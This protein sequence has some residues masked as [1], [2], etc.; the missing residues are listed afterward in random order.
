MWIA[1]VGNPDHPSLGPAASEKH[2]AL[3]NGSTLYVLDRVDGKPVLVRPVG[4]APGAAPAIGEKYVFVP[5]AVGRIEGYPLGE[6]KLT[7]WYYQSFGRAMVS[8]LATPESFVWTTDSG[9]LYVG[10]GGDSLGVRFRLETGSEIVAPA[11]YGPPYVYVATLS[12]EVFSM[13]ELTGQ[14][15]WKY[16]TGFPVTRAPAVV[17]EKVFVTSDEPMLHCVDAVKGAELWTAPQI[18]QFAAASATRAYGVDDFGALVVLDSA[19]GATLGRIPTDASTNALVNDQTDR[20]Y[21]VSAEGVVQCLREIGSKQPMYHR[22]KVEPQPP[23]A[24]AGENQP[25]P[26]AA[27]AEGDEPAE[28]E[29]EETAA[30]EAEEESAETGAMDEEEP[31]D[32]PVEPD[33]G[34]DG[35]PFGGLE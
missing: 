35:D 32:E 25:T 14:R 16:A 24:P 27:E 31:A 15:R 21:L 13:H 17:G 12:G 33:A 10:R 26:P 11:A 6:Q 7:P 9:H 23:V 20:V 34:L 22:P 1:P 18:S 29:D 2:V 19:T 5:L 3:L 8:P 4:G 30:E 28:S